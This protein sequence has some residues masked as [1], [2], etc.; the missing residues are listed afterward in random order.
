M[1]R[2]C[3]S[4]FPSLASH[5]TS[6]TS[7]TSLR[8]VR[9]S[10]L[11]FVIV[12]AFRRC[13]RDVTSRAASLCRRVISLPL[14]NTQRGAARRRIAH[15]CGIIQ[16]RVP[17]SVKRLICCAM[18]VTHLTITVTKNR[19]VSQCRCRWTMGENESIRRNMI[20][21][22]FHGHLLYF[23]VSIKRYVIDP[24]L[25]FLYALIIMYFNK[26]LKMQW[27][28]RKWRI[29]KQNLLHPC[30]FISMSLNVSCVFNKE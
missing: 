17:W 12:V 1:P 16:C 14:N 11:R 29:W 13:S 18:A 26:I 9:Y 2:K 20:R 22:I 19:R 24:F 5:A 27:I 3:S 21:R 15:A 23:L 4:R 7:I 30:D 25:R 6:I 10:R 8:Y 28:S